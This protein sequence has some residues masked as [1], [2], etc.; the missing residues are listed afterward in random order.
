MVWK[1][2]NAIPHFTPIGNTSKYSLRIF[3][4]GIHHY[5]IDGNEESTLISN[6]Q[7]RLFQSSKVALRGNFLSIFLGSPC[8]PH[9]RRNGVSEATYYQIS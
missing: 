4:S 9:S 8:H 6:K 7:P 2:S 1:N 3:I 5:D